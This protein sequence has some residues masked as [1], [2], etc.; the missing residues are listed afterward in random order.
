M[1]SVNNLQLTWLTKNVRTNLDKPFGFEENILTY[2]NEIKLKKSQLILSPF[3]NIY[4]PNFF[5]D[6]QKKLI[7]K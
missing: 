1:L 4:C 2:D 6:R 7:N 3:H 5:L